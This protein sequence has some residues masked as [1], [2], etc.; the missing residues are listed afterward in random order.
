MMKFLVHTE[1]SS[2]NFQVE[3]LKKI[4]KLLEKHKK[5][6]KLNWEDKFLK[7]EK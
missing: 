5:L 4:P 7:K 3:K 1:Y 2:R 6:L